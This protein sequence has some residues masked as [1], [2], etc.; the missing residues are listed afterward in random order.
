M[1]RVVQRAA[2]LAGLTPQHSEVV[3]I[4]HYLP[5]QEYRPHYDWFN[6]EDSRYA[7]KTE[8]MGNR[9]LSFFVYLSD[10]PAGG[11][12]NFPTLGVRFPPQTGAA[13]MWYNIDRHGMLDERTLH[14]GA[15]VKEGEKWGMNIWLRERPNTQRF[16]QVCLVRAAVRV[17]SGVDGAARVALSLSPS[18]LSSNGGMQPCPVCGDLVGPVG[19]CFCKKRYG[20][21]IMD[22]LPLYL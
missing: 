2:Y 15:P 22:Q 8:V 19:L 16:K 13:L 21:E 10:C 18:G 3:Q 14:A 5:G 9:L 17:C 20:Y 7:E 1:Q 4:V 12:T 6:P 11:H